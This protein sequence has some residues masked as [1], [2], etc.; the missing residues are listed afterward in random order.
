MN[1]LES[2]VGWLEG[3]PLAIGD[4]WSIH[5]LVPDR[6][7]LSRAGS[8]GYAIFIE[9]P[10]DSFGSLPPYHGI[11]YSDSILAFP[12]RRELRALKLQSADERIGNRVIAH[13]AYELNRRLDLSP[14]ESGEELMRSVEWILMLLG[15]GEKILSPERRLGLIGECLLMRTLLR[16]GRVNG[17]GPETVLDRWWGY[18]PSHRD[19]SA[20]GVSIEVKTTVHNTRTHRM[21]IEQL[22]PQS[23]TE[24]VYL[25]SLGLKTDPSAPKKLP[26]FVL[27]V[28]AEMLSP[29]TGQPN[30]FAVERFRS[31]LAKYGYDSQMADVY[32]SGP[33]YLA[34]HLAL[35][36]FPERNLGRLRQSS[37][38]GGTPPSSV[39]AITFDLTVDSS[40]VAQIDAILLDLLR[41]PP[42][43]HS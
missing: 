29:A 43:S 11:E 9:G 40:P 3:L 42:T 7:H 33:G 28:E 10:Q 18:S 37:F 25:C 8:G 20:M 2:I 19:F 32:R 22:E 1:S 23:G 27:D 12:S 16:L 6:L 31:D 5:T 36:L 15:E 30:A 35:E 39:S 13:I 14:D 24:M 17:I 41:S 4:N 26:D 34:P 38:V 21:G